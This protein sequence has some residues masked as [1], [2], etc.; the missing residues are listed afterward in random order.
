MLLFSASAI[1]QRLADITLY[2]SVCD[3]EVHVSLLISTDGQAA[4]TRSVTDWPRQSAALT[5]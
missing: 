4:I 2:R 1:R 5:S 3:R